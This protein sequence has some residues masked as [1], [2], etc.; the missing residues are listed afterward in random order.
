M[1]FEK[2][3]RTQMII[4]GLGAAVLF[5]GSARAQEITNAEFNDGPHTV[6]FAQPTEPVSATPA[7]TPVMSETQALLAVAAI[8]MPVV[9]GEDSLVASSELERWVVAGTLF[10]ALGVI[11]FYCAAELRALT[12][13]K[14]ANR[15][16]KTAASMAP[17]TV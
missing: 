12:E 1:T 3:L 6:A 4:A 9:P 13:L 16:P 5:A 7:S 17:R 14:R 11:I 2:L 8:G 15:S 10:I